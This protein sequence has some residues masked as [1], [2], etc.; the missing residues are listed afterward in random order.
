VA[1]SLTAKWKNSLERMV[2]TFDL[3]ARVVPTWENLSFP[4]GKSQV[5]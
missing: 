4:P 1:F 5:I 2:Y 3:S